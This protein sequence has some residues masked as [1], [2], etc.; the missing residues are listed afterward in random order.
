MTAKPPATTPRRGLTPGELAQ[1][2]V[3]AALCAATA[4]IAVVVPFAGGLS[5]LGTVPMGLLAYRYRPRVLIAATVA[6]GTIAFLIAG[7]GGL[8]T[9]MDCAYIGG[10]TG[11]IKR[12]GRGTATAFG[13][14]VV[15]GAVFG[16][17]IVLALTVLTRLR[18]L[19]FD[20][21]T[22][23]IEGI[24][25]VLERIPVAHVA[26][27]PL[28]ATFATMLDYW[29]LLMLLL[30][31]LSIT[32]VSMIGWWALSRILARLLGVPDVHKLDADSEDDAAVIAPVPARLTDVRFRYPGV[33]RDALGP[34]SMELKPGEHVA[35]TGPNGS[36]KTTLML[37]LAGRQP[38]AGTIERAGAVG[39]GRIGGT[40]V[41]MQHPESQVLGTRVADDVVWGLPA[42]ATADVGRLLAEVGLDGLAERDTGGL[43]GGELQRLAVAGAL[44]REPS[45]LIADEVTSMVDQQGRDTLMNVLSGL[46][47]HHQMS[48]VHITHYNDEAD[49]ADRT[50]KLSGNGGTADNTD[51]VQTSAVPVAAAP[52]AHSGAPVLEL[53]GVGHEYASGT[54][55]AKTALRDIT[56]TVNEGDGVLVHG[57]NGSGKSTLAWIMAGLTVPTYGACLL[58]GVPVAQQVGSVAIS[59]QAARL[60]LMRSTVAREIASAAGFSQRE[61]DKIAGALEMVGLDPALAKR[62]IDQLSGGQMRRVVLAGLLARSPRALILDEPLAGLDAA[63]QRGLLRLLEDLRHNNGLTV[64]VISH[65]FTGL[66]GLCPRTLHL[67]RGELALAPTAAGGAR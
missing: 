15:A 29:P 27:E 55:W 21:L 1:A 10:L 46:T 47:G 17:V 6:A 20:S 26:A 3:M 2:A 49:S 18:T 66:E 31:I 45:L 48:L 32:S 38:T 40:A 19:I 7:M 41:V 33:E 61:N 22:A 37:M 56:F 64:V 36:G 44:A 51:M 63:S 50:V 62:R 25:K 23:G 5:V 13:A 53:T 4:I 42:G 43:S 57:L 58:D 54:P 60:Q 14:A 30:G 39:L 24:A 34:V 9:V 65:D 35:V 16:A 12:R 67:H 52:A 59:F 28:R 8:M 11:V